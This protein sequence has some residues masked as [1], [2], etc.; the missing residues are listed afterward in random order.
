MCN[1]IRVH[2]C[3]SLFSRADALL[4][5][6]PVGYDVDAEIYRTLRSIDATRE[7]RR[8]AFS[9]TGRKRVV[10]EGD[11]W[12][13]LPEFFRPPTIADWIQRNGRFWMNNI[14]YWGH[15]LEEILR[16]K[17]Y[18]PAIAE[19]NPDFFMFSAGGNDLQLPI[20]ASFWARWTGL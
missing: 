7:S 2:R 9:F 18:L 5:D 8:E 20:L 10:A 19:D 17:E 1:L 6:R 14:A 11:S 15:T 12:F 16:E 3:Q 4:D 13:N